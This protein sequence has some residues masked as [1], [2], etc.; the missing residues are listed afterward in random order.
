[1]NPKYYDNEQDINVLLEGM[2]IA[3]NLSLTP[4]LQKY[5]ANLFQT[6]FPGCESLTF[7]SDDYLRCIIQTLCF[8]NYHPVGTCKMGAPNDITA[9]VDPHLKVKGVTGLR[10][11]D[12]SIMPTIVSGNTN[13]P[14]VAI[15]EKIADNMKGITI[16]PFTPPMSPSTIENLPNLP[17]EPYSG[18]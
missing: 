15:A 8:T 18:S 12:A 11:V 1:M 14:T 6:K 9:V 2:K 13:A 16:I 4:A 17:T 5:G 10:V 7:Y 3:I